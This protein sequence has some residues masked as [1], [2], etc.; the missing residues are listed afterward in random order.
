MVAAAL[1]GGAFAAEPQ[2][3]NGRRKIV[4]AERGK[5]AAC[6]IVIP[7]A[8]G[9]SVKYAAEELRDYVL[10]MTGVE[11]PIVTGGAGDA[12]KAVYLVCNGQDARCPST[13]ATGRMPVVPVAGE[14]PA[15]PFRR[16]ASTRSAP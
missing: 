13:S 6:S 9:A 1:A 5:K 8:A 12:G 14:T 2:T 11:L 4:L 15:P 7:K 16:P 3:E 10:Q